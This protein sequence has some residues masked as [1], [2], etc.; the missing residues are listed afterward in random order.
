L[1]PPLHPYNKSLDDFDERNREAQLRLDDL[2]DGDNNPPL[3]ARQL[4]RRQPASPST[5]AWW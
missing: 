1:S 3:P 2:C 5:L 4:T